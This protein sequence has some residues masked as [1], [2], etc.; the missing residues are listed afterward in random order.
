MVGGPNEKE[1]GVK[2][3]RTEDPGEEG[4]MKHFHLMKEMCRRKMDSLSLSL[5]FP[6]LVKGGGEG[7]TF[8][9]FK[10]GV[11]GRQEGSGIPDFR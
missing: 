3:S 7:E 4:E 6:W 1:R 8:T 10:S 5:I 2:V 11:K 9:S